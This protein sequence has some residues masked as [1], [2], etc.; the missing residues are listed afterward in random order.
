[1]NILNRHYDRLPPSRDAKKIFIFC[2]GIK[3]ERQYFELFQGLDSH[4]D[5][6]V[7]EIKKGDD[8]SPT[9]LFQLAI[10]MLLNDNFSD[11]KNYDKRIDEVWFVVDTDIWGR[12]LEILYKE[13]KNLNSWFVAQSNPCFEVWLYYHCFEDKPDFPGME[14]SS[15]W[16]DFVNKNIRGGFN[17]RKH[18]HYIGKAIF[19]A[20]KNF[21]QINNMPDIGCTEVYNLAEKIYPLIK[22]KIEE[23]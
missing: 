17:P 5:I 1:M 10:N 3:R 6:I 15:Y 12:K 20:K 22:H 11:E 8:Q 19:N 2:E 9:G 4:I 23:E 7:Y 14:I 16:K 13:C 18:S 21:Q